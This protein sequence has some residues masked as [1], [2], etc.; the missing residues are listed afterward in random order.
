[1]TDAEWQSRH[2]V[3][4]ALV[5][6]HVA[7]LPVFLFCRGF[8][9]WGS[10]EPVLPI[11]IA[12]LL[13]G[14]PELDR[15]VRSVAVVFGLLT[16]SAVLVYG[17]HG[18]IEAH[19]HYFVMI[20]VLAFYEDWLPFGLAIAYVAIEHGVLGA[21]APSAVYNHGG[22]PWEW[23]AVHAAFVLGASAVAVIG[24]RINESTRAGLRAASRRARDESQRFRVSF[25]SGISGMCILGTDGRYLQVNRALCEML[26]YSEQELLRSSPA[27]LTHPEDREREV[28]AVLAAMADGSDVYATEKRYLHRNGSEVWAQIGLRVVR[29]EAGE[30]DYFLLQVNDITERKRFEEELSH[31]AL[32]DALTGLPNRRLFLDRVRGALTRLLRHPNPLTV[33][34]VDLDRFK[35]VNDTL[36]HAIGDEILVQAGR[37]LERALRA[38][39]TV[40]RFGGDEFTIL[41]EGAD[42]HEAQRLGARILD[43]LAEPF[44]HDG[45]EFQ[46]SA[47]VGARVTDSPHVAAEVVIQEADRALYLAKQKGGARVEL[48]HSDVRA[49][50]ADPLATEHA[51]R[52]AIGNGELRLHYQPEVDLVSGGIVALEALVRWQHPER[53]LLGPLEFV[54]LAEQSGLILRVGQWVLHEACAQLASWRAAGIADEAMHVAV[55]VSPRQLAD[56]GL[57]A[58]VAAALDTSGLDPRALCIEIT[59]NALAAEPEITLANLQAIHSLGVGVAL[60]DFGVGFS[61]LSR[62][63]E[64][65]S[66]DVLKIDRSFVAGMR[67]SASDAAVVRAAVSLGA[68][69]GLTVVAEGIEERE[70]QAELQAVGCDVGQGFLFSRPQ[71]PDYISALLSGHSQPPG[72]LTRRTGLGVRDAA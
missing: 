46:L 72:N 60:D 18:Q 4:L 1:L 64:L 44:E 37:R 35:L 50:G 10:I 61:S 42:A 68:H 14:R 25:E 51:L 67:A 71:P 41:C 69:L 39:D 11:V 23:A 62:I 28:E 9:A 58:A 56:P 30:V 16:A 13:G 6:V 54:P 31:R 19:F 24:W 66:L 29:N 55:N 65:P 36:G 49:G 22:S 12:G 43:V 2:H 7:G 38:Q 5:W 63:R 8:G 40:A 48:F 53:G 26:G 3:I 33:L 70:Q 59:E 21:L 52:H 15:R 17:W 34:F 32:H 45:R 57:S 20:G 27:A 47:S